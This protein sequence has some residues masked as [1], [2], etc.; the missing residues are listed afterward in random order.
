MCST[1]RRP[2]RDHT[3]RDRTA[4]RTDRDAERPPGRVRGAID[5]AVRADQLELRDRLLLVH[6][7]EVAQR[8]DLFSEQFDL[9]RC[10]HAPASGSS[11]TFRVSSGNNAS[12]R[13]SARVLNSCAVSAAMLWREN[14]IMTNTLAGGVTNP[15]P[16]TRSE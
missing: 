9:G 4:P 10:G 15:K 12:L 2:V 6:G 5:R 1:I 8:R 13:L 7:Q 11:N 14:R 16:M 3:D